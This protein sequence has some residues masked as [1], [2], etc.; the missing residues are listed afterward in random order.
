MRVLVALVIPLAAG[1][2]ASRAQA[3]P[4]PAEPDAP[5]TTATDAV[6]AT[7]DAPP[8]AR[9]RERQAEAAD[10]HL[11][12]WRGTVAADAEL[13]GGALSGRSTLRTSGGIID[14]SVGVE[15]ALERARWRLGLP[16]TV[17][18]RETPGA[19]LRETRG[20]VDLDA[21]WKR[22]PRLRVDLE[23]GLRLVS[24]PGW[25]D[26]YQPIAGGLGTTDR[27]S[28]RDLRFGGAVAGIPVRHH[29]ARVGLRYTDYDYVDDPAYDGLDAPTHLV[30]GDRHEVD[31]DG[32]WRYFGDR[33]KLGGALAFEDRRDDKSYA[34]DAGTGLT[35]AGPGGPPPNPLYHQLSIEPSIGGEVDLRGET[36]EL[37]ADLGYVV[38]SDRYQ[39]YYSWSGLHPQV[40]ARWHEGKLDAKVSGEL[41][42]A[43]YGDGSYAAGPTHPALESG[44]RR[45]DTKVQGRAS[46]AYEVA[47]HVAA[48]GGV[49]LTNRTTNF[50]DY[51]PGVFPAGRQYDVQWDYVN[52]EVT[53]GVR[54]ER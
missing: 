36:I 23:A 2:G 10:F 40:H 30:P 8:K 18:H 24:R 20:G 6:N 38:V 29:H 9:K 32:S 41:Q 7:S 48:V 5:T 50:P 34:R 43:N 35:H 47:H 37:G 14:G 45:A 4:E 11:G 13:R 12:T 15:P 49:E 51:V 19:E 53:V 52:W 17:G 28:H 46:V 33:W 27:Y 16:I 44:T 21:R 42:L 54:V 22:S 1:V 39:G 25:E 31:I 26:E 3:Q